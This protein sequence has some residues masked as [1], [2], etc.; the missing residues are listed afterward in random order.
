[1][2]RI[3]TFATAIALC[4]GTTAVLNN[5]KSITKP[6]T[7][8]EAI[9][10]MDGAFRDGLYLGKLTADRRQP[11]HPGIGRWSSE[12]DRAMFTAGYRRG[13]CAV[14]AN[15]QAHAESARSAE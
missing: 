10:A 8:V 14:V 13:Y 3:S 11:F 4:L 12:Q 9:F 5:S 15:A 1:M 7:N 2:Y 6:T